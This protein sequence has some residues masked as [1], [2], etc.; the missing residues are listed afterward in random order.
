MKRE[1]AA[2]VLLGDTRSEAQKDGHVGF[3]F[4]KRM[5]WNQ[6]LPRWKKCVRYEVKYHPKGSLLHSEEEASRRG[7]VYEQ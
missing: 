6:A 1:K 5:S 2:W 7:H 4:P 3:Y